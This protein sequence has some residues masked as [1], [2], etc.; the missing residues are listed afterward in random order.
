MEY[1]QELIREKVKIDETL[2]RVV[3]TLPFISDPSD[4]LIGKKDIATRRLEN[5]CRKY[6]L[7][8]EVKEMLKKPWTS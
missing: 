3:A 5:V 6:G 8:D 1:E 4:K 7:N 2:N